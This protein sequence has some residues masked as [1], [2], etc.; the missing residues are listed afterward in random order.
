MG[1]EN[2]NA[3]ET[4]K[5]T[6]PAKKEKPKSIFERLRRSKTAKTLA[7]AGI[8][9]AGGA[10]FESMRGD[11]KKGE[12]RYELVGDREIELGE[13]SRKFT[14]KKEIDGKNPLILH[15]GQI[16]GADSIKETEAAIDLQKLVEHQKDLEKLMAELKEKYG[17]KQFFVEGIAPDVLELVRAVKE[18]TA[19]PRSDSRKD[20]I[21]YNNNLSAMFHNIARVGSELTERHKAYLLYALKTAAEQIL[22][23]SAVESDKELT[24]GLKSIV[25]NMKS[26]ELIS[27][28]KM[29]VWGA[30]MKMYLEG[31]IDVIAAETTEANQEAFAPHTSEEDRRNKERRHNIREDAALKIINQNTGRNRTMAPLVYGVGHDF[32]DNVKAANK[33]ALSGGMG[34]LK[35]EPLSDK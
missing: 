25:E 22:N 24:E 16:H 21:E 27:G 18:K 23:S 14:L 8:L 32:F 9:G 11:A 6:A 28:D 35:I 34:L 1:I 12:T 26:N 7:F 5:E 10:A 13:L 30:P 2:L 33:Y 15:I 20:V 19:A 29:Y 17:L 31:K 4:P 3:V